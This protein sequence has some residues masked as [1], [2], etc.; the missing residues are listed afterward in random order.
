ML[1]TMKIFI[2]ALAGY[3]VGHNLGWTRGQT[4]LRRESWQSLSEMPNWANKRW[5]NPTPSE[6]DKQAVQTMDETDCMQDCMQI[7]DAYLVG[8]CWHSDDGDCMIKYHTPKNN[9]E[10]L[11]TQRS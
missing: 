1:T 8:R 4:E 2:A 7:A 11:S 3:I 10:R 6:V 5:R 9:K